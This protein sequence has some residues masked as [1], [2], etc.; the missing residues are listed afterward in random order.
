M[1][2]IRS[3]SA[4]REPISNM[5]N[6]FSRRSFKGEESTK[7]ERREEKGNAKRIYTQ[8][9]LDKIR[10]EFQF[11]A[12][13][14]EINTTFESLKGELDK[15][16]EDIKDNTNQ[17]RNIVSTIDPPTCVLPPHE[18]PSPPLDFDRIKKRFADF[19]VFCGEKSREFLLHFK[20]L[21]NFHFGETGIDERSAK[22]LLASKLTPPVFTSYPD[23]DQMSFRDLFT[24]LLSRYDNSENSE[25]AIDALLDL[26]RNVTSYSELIKE[27][28]RLHNLL[29]MDPASR[30]RIF[31]IGIRNAIPQNAKSKL[32][33]LSDVPPIIE[34]IIAHTKPL[35]VEI[36]NHLK[37]NKS[38]KFRSLEL[39]HEPREDGQDKSYSKVSRNRPNEICTECID[40]HTASN[41]RRH[42]TCDICGLKNHDKKDCRTRRCQLCGSRKHKSVTCTVYCNT[43]PIAGECLFCRNRYNIQ[44]RH[45]ERICLKRKAQK[46]S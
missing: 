22:Y 6:I 9:D 10:N 41:C 30:F 4:G 27:A 37:L 42:K 44:L 31:Y 35:S 34:R 5:S 45:D 33:F 36:D 15:K 14:Q 11:E 13:K 2:R 26:A 1:E 17:H 21:C 20:T 39:T 38:K 40:Y 7:D 46:N 43:E 18:Y 3:L 12:M 28:I 24:S 16:L 23:I 8:N 25:V 32:G 19:P 29:K